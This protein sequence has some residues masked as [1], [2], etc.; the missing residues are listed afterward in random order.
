MAEL[1]LEDIVGFFVAGG[2]LLLLGLACILL[3]VLWPQIVAI[4][5]AF[6]ARHF[7]SDWWADFL[8]WVADRREGV[9]DYEE[10]SEPRSGIA[11]PSS[12]I[13]PS[14]PPPVLSH[15]DAADTGTWIPVREDLPR[16]A[17]LDILARQRIDNKYVFSGNKLVELFAGSPHAASRNVI[18]DEVA[19]IRRGNEPEQPKQAG[20]RLERPA[21]GWA[22]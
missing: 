2:I 13:E 7:N 4:S 21:N 17:L 3:Y 19:K 11:R 18:L 1:R 14:I 22:K 10:R 6:W 16:S 8:D 20:Q 12:G 5:R 15:Q 9:N